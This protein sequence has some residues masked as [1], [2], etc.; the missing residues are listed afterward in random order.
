MNLD[1][2]LCVGEGQSLAGKLVKHWIPV[3]S[4]WVGPSGVGWGYSWGRR[5][6][7][8]AKGVLF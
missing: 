6:A 8:A 2:T 1:A 5:C 4:G 3:G 7:A